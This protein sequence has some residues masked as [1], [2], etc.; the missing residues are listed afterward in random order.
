M[1]NFVIFGTQRTGTTL[2]CTSLNSHS[3]ILCLGELFDLNE[4]YKPK[5]MP[6]Y[7][8]FIKNILNSDQSYTIDI[9]NQAS[10]FGFLQKKENIYSYLDQ[11]YSKTP[12]KGIGFKLMLNQVKTFPFIFECIKSKNLKIIKVIRQNILDTHISRVRS[13]KTSVFHSTEL[14]SNENLSALLM[15]KVYIDT[16][17]LIQ[18]LDAIAHEN[19]EI[20][21]IV[22]SSGL[23]YITI[24]YNSL[25]EDQYAEFKRILSFLDIKG[26]KKFLI[27]EKKLSSNLKKVSPSELKD[28]V[29]NYD[30]MINTLKSSK[31]NYFLH[32]IMN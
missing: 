13:Q 24:Q 29:E 11:F 25:L 2:V 20:D 28:S 12:Y 8:V 31:Y 14:K 30:D 3:K 10:Y 32:S 1:T 6:I 18:D 5:E 21:T 27:K 22:D 9:N 17:T 4:S 7:G 15:Y 19:Q 16:N 23:N 26:E